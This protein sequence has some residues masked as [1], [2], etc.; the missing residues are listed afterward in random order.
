DCDRVVG[1]GAHHV[2][3]HCAAY[4]CAF[5]HA[6][7]LRRLT[8]WVKSRQTNAPFSSA[9][10]GE[11]AHL[12]TLPFG[13]RALAYAIIDNLAVIESEIQVLPTGDERRIGGI[14]SGTGIIV[15]DSNP[16]GDAHDVPSRVTMRIGINS[17][18]QDAGR[19]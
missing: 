19:D 11:S 7:Q 4:P 6:V 2:V 1:K 5:G 8:A 17:D 12:T 14:I 18:Q 9:A 16:V 3:E 10:A 15:C 13:L